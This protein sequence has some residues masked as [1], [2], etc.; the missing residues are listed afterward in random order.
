MTKEE[1]IRA[2][3]GLEDDTE[4]VVFVRGHFGRREIY[5]VKYCGM[6]KDDPAYMAIMARHCEPCL[7]DSQSETEGERG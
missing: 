7:T 2:L 3:D 5:K 6:T 1:L 4:V